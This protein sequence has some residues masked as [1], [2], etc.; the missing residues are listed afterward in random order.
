MK[1]PFPQIKNPQL[2]DRLFVKPLKRIT[3]NFDNK[4]KIILR[5]FLAMERTALA[6]ERTLFSYIRSGIYLVLAAVAFIQLEG[7]KPMRWVGFTLIGLSLFLFIFGIVR[8][9]ILQKKLRGFYNTMEKEEDSNKPS[10]KD[11]SKG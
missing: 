10:E 4:E 1:T 7:F 2:K 6:N 5:D 3:K 8:Y 11:K 9:R